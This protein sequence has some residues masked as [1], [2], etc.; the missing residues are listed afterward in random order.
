MLKRVLTALLLLPFSQSASQLP[1]SQA[2]AALPSSQA[3]LPLFQVAAPLPSSQVAPPLPP[4]HIVRPG[5]TLSA[6]ADLYHLRTAD[7]RR[8]NSLTRDEV[9]RPDGALRLSGSD[10]YRP[11]WA[12]RV[13]TVTATE[14]NGDPA[15]KC[16]VPPESLRRVWV[17]YTD[18][19][20]VVHDGNL[21]VHQ[22]IVPATQRAFA[23]LYAW[24]FPV[25][26]MAPAPGFPDRSVL[27]SGYECRTVAGTT[28]W[29]QHAYGL[30]IDVNP[31]QNPMIRG[32]YLDPPH[33][34]PWIRRLPYRTGMIHDNGAELAFTTNGF[35]WGGRW[36]SLK[37]YMHFSPTNL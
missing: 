14:A 21:I 11:A 7:L 10:Q 30:A 15:K 29:S 3:A 26:A 25:M 4:G 1:F 13:E 5:D 34:E 6:I 16:P 28:K 18:F 12:T 27:T 24:H 37:D 31:R 8:W 22:S 2:A 17:R 23:L 32:T 9:L 20:G 33:S 19:N 36:H 35:A